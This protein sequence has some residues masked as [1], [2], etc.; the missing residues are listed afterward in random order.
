TDRGENRL[1]GVMTDASNM[2]RDNGTYSL[3]DRR[4]MNNLGSRRW[5]TDGSFKQYPVK[6]SLLAARSVVRQGGETQFADMRAAYEALP[7]DLKQHIDGLTVEHNL[8]HSRRMV[9]FFE[10]DDKERRERVAVHQPL[11]R[12]H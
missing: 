3:G 12:V 6:Y 5:H 1:P 4:R 7:D 9:G 2:T 11:V 10:A 8:L